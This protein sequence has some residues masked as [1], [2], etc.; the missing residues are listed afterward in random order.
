MNEMKRKKNTRKM[1]G[2]PPGKI[3]AGMTCLLCFLGAAFFDTWCGVQSRRMG[4]EIVQTRM[5]QEKLF[6][7]QKKLKIEK[8]SLTS[9]Q[10]LRRYATGELSLQIPKPEQI[11]VVP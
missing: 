6:D 3:I 9:P 10:R 4:Y 11:I 5:Q 8:S 2:L 7:Y 1:T